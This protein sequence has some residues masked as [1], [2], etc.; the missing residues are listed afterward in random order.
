M[1]FDE[2]QTSNNGFQQFVTRFQPVEI[3]SHDQCDFSV[4]A[5]ANAWAIDIDLAA[6]D[7]LPTFKHFSHNFDRH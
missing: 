7:A 6:T 2:S 4:L 3:A 5:D 1:R